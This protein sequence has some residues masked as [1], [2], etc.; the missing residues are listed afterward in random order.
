MF[1]ELYRRVFE[2]SSRS[3]RTL[4]GCS[5]RGT[6]LSLETLEVRA[7]P[8]TITVTG[9]GDT[10]AVDGLITLREAITAAN[11][12]AVSGDAAAGDAGLDT[13]NFNIA[14]LPGTVHT[15]QPTIALPTVTEAIVINGYSQLGA[16]P[17][18]LPNGDNAF[19]AIELDGTQSGF[20]A[21]LVLSGGNSTV[22]GL[23]INRFFNEGILVIGGSGNIIRG[24]FL[25]TDATGKLDRG[26]DISGISVLSSN[27]TIGGTAPA[28]RNII[29]GNDFTGVAVLNQGISGNQIL[30]NFIGTDDTGLAGLGNNGAGV[31]IL[32]VQ[33]NTVGGTQA[34]AGNVIAFNSGDGIQVS[35]DAGLG[36][37]FLGNSIHSN[38]DLGIDLNSDGPTPNDPLDADSG[39]NGLQNTPVLGTVTTNGSGVTI[40]GTL[41][42]AA[43]SSFRVEFFT[44]ASADLSGFGEGQ[45]FLGFA[46]VTT[47]A[48][49]NGSFAFSTSA[50]VP[51]S[52]LISATA[53]DAAGSTSEFS[54]VAS[55]VTPNTASL[56][57]ATL[58]VTGT[59]GSDVILIEPRPG[60]PSQIRVK[61][62]GKSLGAFNKSDVG[63]I[64]AS[65]LGGNDTIIVNASLNIPAELHGNAGNDQLYGS[66]ASDQL[67]GEAGSDSLF[68][69]GGDDLLDGG[70]GADRLE[71]QAGDDLLLGGGAND[72]LFGQGGRDVLIGGFGSDDLFGGADDD[73]VIGGTTDH[74]ANVQAL[75]LILAEWSSSAGIGTRI[76]N[77]TL[78]GGLNDPFLLTPGDTV[79]SDG[80]VD[81]LTGEA[82][83]DWFFRSLSDGDKLLDLNAG[84]DRVAKF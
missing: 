77:L 84:K 26:N 34:G 44:N 46:H 40:T 36:N 18:T 10:I 23:V 72:K 47:D 3:R 73:I 12:N 29:S 61:V 48:A 70:T 62:N 30:G 63:R 59:G 5:R 81:R 22:Q 41:L 9:T 33:G 80:V 17:N 49:G 67:F 68:G 7:V 43:S 2:T 57:G 55:A 38:G 1:S 76:N 16:S 32:N 64:T 28:D 4:K 6:R 65:G 83:L 14:G 24:N 79:H 74:D 37:A 35:N 21:G 20:N 8:A 52:T 11:T 19:L 31:R 27:N 50:N 15:I 69:L 54:R 25:G 53:T 58:A 45:T 39:P 71:G 82:G 51:A 42:A 78:G 66:H 13:I 60:S 56:S 75:T